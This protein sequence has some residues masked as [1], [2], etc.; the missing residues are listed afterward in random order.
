MSEKITE[1]QELV[2]RI[3]KVGNSAL[4]TGEKFVESIKE[5]AEMLEVEDDGLDGLPKKYPELQELLEKL[6]V[7]EDEIIG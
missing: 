7:L 1:E 3:I 5:W 6:T 2:D 4:V